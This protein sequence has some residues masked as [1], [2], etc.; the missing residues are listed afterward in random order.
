MSLLVVAHFGGKGKGTAYRR[1]GHRIN[2]GFEIYIPQN[3]KAC[4]PAEQFAG[5]GQLTQIMCVTSGITL[6]RFTIYRGSQ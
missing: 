5:F 2:E 1:S 6:P 3:P 4:H